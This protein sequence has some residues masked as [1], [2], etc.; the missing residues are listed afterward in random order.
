MKAFKLTTTALL[1]IF[2]YLAV[3]TELVDT[4]KSHG[5]F[6]YGY[7]QVDMA[8]RHEGYVGI[9]NALGEVFYYDASL[10]KGEGE[11]LEPNVILDLIYSATQGEATMVYA[12]AGTYSVSVSGGT[13]VSEI[14]VTDSMKNEITG[15]E[16]LFDVAG[17]CEAP[18]SESPEV[19]VSP[20]PL[21]LDEEVVSVVSNVVD[22]SIFI[23]SETTS[24]YELYSRS[25]LEILSGDLLVGENIIAV[26]AINAGVYLLTVS[27]ESSYYSIDILIE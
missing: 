15:G 20:K 18:V 2:S 17:T 23:T 22:E 6:G 3:A 14:F 4:C 12:S 8:I 21:S 13:G 24:V 5:Y 19:E 1:T 25:G 26:E 11:E 27:S 7:Y 9:E 16:F 10:L